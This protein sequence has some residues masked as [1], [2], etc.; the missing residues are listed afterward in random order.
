[1]KVNR[2][3]IT[4]LQLRRGFEVNSRLILKMELIRALCHLPASIL[5]SI[6]QV[7]LASKNLC[8]RLSHF[9]CD[10]LDQ[11]SLNQTIN[12]SADTIMACCVTT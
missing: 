11:V 12:E 9:G 2:L 8:P 6:R 7:Q 1:M 3:F 5:T 10:F 4:V